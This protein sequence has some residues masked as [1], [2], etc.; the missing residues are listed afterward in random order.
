[1]K[2]LRILL[3]VCHEVFGVVFPVL[4]VFRLRIV[5]KMGNGVWWL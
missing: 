2:I 5:S 4:H 3:V 1:M